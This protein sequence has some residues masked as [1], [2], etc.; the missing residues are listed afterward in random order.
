MPELHHRIPYLIGMGPAYKV[1]FKPTR[2]FYEQVAQVGGV[3]LVGRSRSKAWGERVGTYWSVRMRKT[4]RAPLLFLLAMGAFGGTAAQSPSNQPRASGM[5]T[6]VAKVKEAMLGN[7]ESIAPEI[8][9]SKNPDGSLKP[10]YLK[11]SYKYLPSDRFELVIVN[12]ADPFGAVPLARI[13]IGGHMLREGP[14]PDAPGTEKD[15]FVGDETFRGNP[16]A[17]GFVC[18]LNQG[19]SAGYAPSGG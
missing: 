9:P 1:F 14:P 12:S 5:E 18:G 3:C 16:P 2:G 13:K 6:D 7:W 8:R 4:I 11:R 15:D 17:P 10:F 19:A